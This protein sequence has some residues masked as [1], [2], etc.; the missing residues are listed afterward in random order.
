MYSGLRT[1][2]KYTSALDAIKLLP[3]S[4]VDYNDLKETKVGI[5]VIMRAETAILL[6]ISNKIRYAAGNFAAILHQTHKLTSLYKA[7][8][9]TTATTPYTLIL[10]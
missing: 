1:G 9:V 2:T 7:V 3:T 5:S 10:T 6:W 8:F 4:G